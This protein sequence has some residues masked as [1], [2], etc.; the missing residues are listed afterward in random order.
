VPRVEL[1]LHTSRSTNLATENVRLKDTLDFENKVNQD[2]LSILDATINLRTNKAAHRGHEYD[3]KHFKT[4]YEELHRCKQVLKSAKTS[5]SDGWQAV[6]RQE[7]GCQTWLKESID[8]Y[9][10]VKAVG[11]IESCQPYEVFKFLRDHENSKHPEY[12]KQT[13]TTLL[14]EHNSGNRIYRTQYPFVSPFSA[15]D[16]VF[17]QR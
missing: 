2:H 4:E 12:M 3:I 16:L 17:R 13:E 11:T 14:D 8:D 9:S 1:K 15:R 6:G 10:I 5:K 7:L